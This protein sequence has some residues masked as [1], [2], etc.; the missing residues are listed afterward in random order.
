MGE[1]AVRRGRPALGIAEVA[2]KQGDGGSNDA[3]DEGDLAT[4]WAQGFSRVLS[5]SV[6]AIVDS[7][8]HISRAVEAQVLHPVDTSLHLTRGCHCA[9]GGV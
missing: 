9:R 2:D 7:P 5:T 3:Q 1:R 8:K 4:A 6:D